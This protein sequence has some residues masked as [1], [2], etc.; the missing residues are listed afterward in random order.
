[1]TILFALD[2]RDWSEKTLDT[3]RRWITEVNEPLL[4][5]FY[6]CNELSACLGFPIAPVAD[7]S[8]FIRTPNFVFTVEGFHD[9]VNNGTIQEDVDFCLLKVLQFVYAPIF[10]NF[11]WN[12]NVKSR[13]CKAMEKFLSYL[14]N[15]NS[16]MAG[17]TLLYVPYVVKQMAK[18]NI[19][20]DREFVKNMES[21]VVFWSNQIRTLLN[22]KVLVVPHGMVVLK[23]EYEFWIY[24][25]K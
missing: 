25:C 24:R 17:M 10:N 4:T 5:I 13:F 22:D 23:E 15:M 9:E 8:Y 6:D 7:L 12:E 16:K 1:M 18:E 3:I 2:H 14:T 21:I 19:G 20:H 11:D